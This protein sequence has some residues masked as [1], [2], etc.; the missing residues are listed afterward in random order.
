MK[1]KR[2]LFFFIPYCILN[3]RNSLSY[4]HIRI[5]NNHQYRCP[6]VISPIKYFYFINVTDF[7]M[8]VI[9]LNDQ[10]GKR[11]LIM[12]SGIKTR[13]LKCVYDPNPT[14]FFR[15]KNTPR[16]YSNIVLK[17]GYYRKCKIGYISYS[18]LFYTITRLCQKVIF[19]GIKF[20]PF[21]LLYV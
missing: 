9:L 11:K 16:I 15:T 21:F 14:Y 13:K 2:F 17:I 10:K 3:V 20:V 18:R 7:W 19:S 1:L 12:T 5:E 8:Q 6:I 4:E